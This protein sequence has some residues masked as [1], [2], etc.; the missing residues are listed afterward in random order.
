MQKL[1]PCSKSTNVPPGQISC[2]N[3]SLVINSPERVARIPR[4]L[5]GCCCSLTGR[6]LRCSSPLLI[7]SSKSPKRTIADRVKTEPESGIELP[8]LAIVP[9]DSWHQV[10]GLQAKA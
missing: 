10:R 2:L 5:Q 1:M 9:F 8:G 7:E 4:T 3:S 6:P